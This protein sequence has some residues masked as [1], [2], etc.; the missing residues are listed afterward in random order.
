MGHQVIYCDCG[1]PVMEGRNE[2]KCDCGMICN[3]RTDW[4]W[5]KVSDYQQDNTQVKEDI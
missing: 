1:K 4:K 3:N 5:K 2:W